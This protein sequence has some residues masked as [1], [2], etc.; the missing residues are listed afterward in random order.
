MLFGPVPN[1]FGPLPVLSLS[2][3]QPCARAFF[4][5]SVGPPLSAPPSRQNLAAEQTWP[6]LP[7]TR[8]DRI[9]RGLGNSVAQTPTAFAWPIN[10]LALELT[11]S[12]DQKESSA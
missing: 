8:H 6:P 9:S 7:R 3:P 1:Q 11:A 12:V 5:L 4:S 2:S 10:S